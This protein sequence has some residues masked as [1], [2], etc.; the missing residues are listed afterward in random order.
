MRRSLVPTFICILSLFCSYSYAQWTEPV[1]ISDM[2]GICPRAVAVAETLHVVAQTSVWTTYLR[3]PDNGE[4]WTEP[5]CPVEDFYG[6]R[7]PDI[8]SS[9]G[10]LHMAFIGRY[11]SGEP[12]KVYTIR[13][14]NGGRSWGEPY[15]VYYNGWKYPRLAGTGDTLFLSCA[16]PGHILVFSSYNNGESW[17]GP[18]TAE[19][20]ASAIDSGPNVLYSQGRLHLVYQMSN[21]D[22]TVGI[23]IYYRYSDDHGHTWSERIYVST[24]EGVPN[25]KHSQFPSAIADSLGNLM[26]LW[27]DYKYGSE[28]GFTG[29][30][31]GRA[32]R[33]NGETWLPE[34]RLTY[35]QTGS[36][37]S[38][39]ILEDT[40]YAIWMDEDYLGCG[41]PKLMH[42]KS[43]DWGATWDRPELIDESAEL[44]EGGPILFYN[45]E[46]ISP[47]LHCVMA[48]EPVNGPCDL[49]YTWNAIATK[50]ADAIPPTF[51]GSFVLGAYPNPF[52]SS[53]VLTLKCGGG[54]D[55]T[56][57]IYDVRGRL[58]KRLDLSY[59]G[60]GDKKTVWD[61]TDNSGRRVSSGIYFARVVSNGRL[62]PL[63]LIYLK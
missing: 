43:G 27:F 39:V 10:K 57:G 17:S 26:A 22:D 33:D 21:I 5:I 16:I 63:K 18:F 38:C 49:Y 14:S 52:N 19:S 12:T 55:E 46:E 32:S 40:L 15:E 20:E 61:A 59:A 47:M 42:S 6:S 56:I 35:T 44:L 23:E 13:S 7:T 25:H 30:I 3:S 8:I 34:T 50:T 54:G 1:R 62:P 45:R 2:P 53:T 60:G 24:P 36:S 28:C 37:S 48:G 58:V 41:Y 9:N 4:T 31:L 11:Q 29:D 51:P